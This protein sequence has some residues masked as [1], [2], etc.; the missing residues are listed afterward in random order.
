MGKDSDF[1][2]GK[3]DGDSF[4]QHG[5]EHPVEHGAGNFSIP[6]ERGN[7]DYNKG[8]DEGRKGQ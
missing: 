3:A 7:D 2:R 8:V 4:R 1:D 5:N 6:S